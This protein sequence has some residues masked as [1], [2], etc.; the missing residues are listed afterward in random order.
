MKWGGKSRNFMSKIEYY[1]VCFFVL[2]AAFRCEKWVLIPG[3]IFLEALQHHITVDPCCM[4]STPSILPGKGQVKRREYFL[5]PQMM[6]LS[7]WE[8]RN[9]AVFAI[10]WSLLAVDSCCASHLLATLSVIFPSIDAKV[11]TGHASFCTCLPPPKISY[12]N[13]Q[14]HFAK[15]IMEVVMSF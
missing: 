12:R 1:W 14:L 4:C 9:C 5:S 6:A 3:M 15:L 7:L 2:A 13:K 11:Y 8:E 10:C